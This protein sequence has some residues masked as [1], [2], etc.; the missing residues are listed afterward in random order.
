MFLSSFS[1]ISSS[2]GFVLRLSALRKKRFD[3]SIAGRYRFGTDLFS[4]FFLFYSHSNYIYFWQKTNEWC[5]KNL[6][7]LKPLWRRRARR[8]AKIVSLCVKKKIGGLLPKTP[9]SAYSRPMFWHHGGW[10]LHFFAYRFFFCYLDL[11]STYGGCQSGVLKFGFLS[12]GVF[13]LGSSSWGP[14]VGVLKSGSS[15]S[16]V[17]ERTVLVRSFGKE[18]EIFFFFFIWLRLRVAHVWT[19]LTDRRWFKEIEFLKWAAVSR[20]L[21]YAIY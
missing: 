13:K 3:L 9:R 10:R 19:L 5:E 11:R 4:I 6:F 2:R 16:S 1:M 15:S 17:L 7:Y 20:L 14:Q 8:L 12:L 21:L 18:E